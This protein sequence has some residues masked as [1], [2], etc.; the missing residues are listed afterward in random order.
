[1]PVCAAGGTATWIALLKSVSVTAIVPTPGTLVANRFTKPCASTHT[2]AGM[3]SLPSTGVVPSAVRLASGRSAANVE[4]PIVAEYRVP[5]ASEPAGAA[6][7]GN[8]IDESMFFGVRPVTRLLTEAPTFD[9]FDT[10]T[11]GRPVAPSR[12]AST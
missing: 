9:E 11:Q 4:R 7:I 12:R 3:A 6:V 8:W 10:F 2:S 1:M 5:M